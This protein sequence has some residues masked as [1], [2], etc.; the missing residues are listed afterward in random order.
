L[1]YRIAKTLEDED[2]PTPHVLVELSKKEQ[3]RLSA[4][5]IHLKGVTSC[6][7]T[8]QLIYKS[9]TYGTNIRKRK[10][11]II[12]NGNKF[13]SYEI[14]LQSMKRNFC[15]I[16]LEKSD[17]VTIFPELLTSSSTYN[18]EPSGR[19]LLMAC[20]YKPVPKTSKIWDTNDYKLIKKC[21]PNIL[22]GSNHHESTGYYASF[23]NKGSY[24]MVNSSSVGQYTTELQI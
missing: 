6:Q 20:A 5:C 7:S 16:T 12:Y 18:E 2:A 8:G 15:I 17:A 11:S 23:G 22:Q 4:N 1:S 21:K 19:L 14:G 9:V 10:S 24:E 3:S 13:Q